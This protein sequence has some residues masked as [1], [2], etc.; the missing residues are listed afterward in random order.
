[1]KVLYK[2]FLIGVL[3]I[4]ISM[5]GCVQS[6]I[7]V[8]NGEIVFQSDRDLNYNLYIMESDGSRLENLTKVPFSNTEPRSNVNPAPSP[9]GKHIAFESDRDWNIEIYIIDIENGVQLNLTNNK[10]NDYSPTWSPNGKKIAFISDRDAV[11]VNSERGIS[12]NNIYIMNADGSNV[13]RLTTNNV[14]AGYGGLSWSPDGMKLAFNLS[15]STP[16][17]GYFAMGIHVLTISNSMFTNLTGASDNRYCCPKWSPDGKYI[18]YSVL[19]VGSK[20]IYVMNADGSNKIALTH[21][22]SYFDTEPSWSP[23]GKYILFSS[24]RD[25]QYHIYSMNADGSNQ[26]RLTDGPAKDSFPVWLPVP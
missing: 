8:K 7:G 18:L 1:M 16:A 3:L 17:G 19:D 4:A 11:V 26:N 5:D 13:R 24:N 25:G 22:S 15:N 21:N 2:L 23:D 14:T 10:T 20:S 12:T 6:Q 9:D